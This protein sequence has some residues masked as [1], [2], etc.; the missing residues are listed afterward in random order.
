VGLRSGSLLDRIDA[1]CDEA[2]RLATDAE[3][4][5]SLL[6]FVPEAF[7]WIADAS[8]A[9]SAAAEGAGLVVSD[10]PLMVLTDTAALEAQ[11]PPERIELRLATPEDD[12]ATFWSVAAVGF[13]HPGTAVG[14]AG[15]DELAAAA[16]ERP[17]ELVEFERERLRSGATVLSIALD[18][19]TPVAMGAHQP[20]GDATEIVGVATLPAF[21]RRGLGAAVTAFLVEDARKRGLSTIFLSAG[22]DEIARLYGSLGFSRVGT[23]C[24]AEPG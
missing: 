20:V 17:A 12:L 8:P 24:A 2:P 15:P 6:L 5:G 19:G 10:L 22:S 3:D 14:A 23:A 16:A 13:A 4:I 11:S 9:M 18:G 7:E 1:Y 21:R